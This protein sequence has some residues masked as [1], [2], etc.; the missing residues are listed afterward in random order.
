MWLPLD[1]VLLLYTTGH[2]LLTAVPKMRKT[3]HRTPLE[4]NYRVLADSDLSEPQRAFLSRFDRDLEKLGYRPVLTFAAVRNN[5]RTQ[6]L[7]RDYAHPSDTAGCKVMVAESSSKGPYGRHVGHGASVVFVTRF[8][9]G[10]RFCTSN[11]SQ[12]RMFN[13]VPGVTTQRLRNVDNLAELKRRH[14]TWIPRNELPLAP[15]S[16]PRDFL[17]DAR[18][19]HLAFVQHQIAT[20][21]FRQDPQSQAA[22]ATDKV[23]W[24]ALFRRYN[25]FTYPIKGLTVFGFVLPPLLVL[26]A[27]LRADDLV[28]LMPFW[29]KL[30]SPNIAA[31]VIAS[32]GI[33]IAGILEGWFLP[34]HV[35][36]WD[37]ALLY[38][39]LVL[40]G[41]TEPFPAVVFFSAAILATYAGQLRNRGKIILLNESAPAA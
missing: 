9:G 41:R 13:P 14:D 33:A 29:L 17:A 35:A 11:A 36:L 5:G 22:V 3:A 32:A 12:V 20:G 30:F 6:G 27:S 38:L 4:P 8:A 7:A 31:R 2:F 15:L 25:L 26:L 21:M 18:Q 16:T 37:F 28:R 34:R 19:Q 39:P 23:H 10:R 1:L 24:R 40:W